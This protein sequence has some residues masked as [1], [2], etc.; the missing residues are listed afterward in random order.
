MKSRS[1]LI[2]VSFD[3]AHDAPGTVFLDNGQTLNVRRPNPGQKEMFNTA[4]KL[5]M[6]LILMCERKS[7][8]IFIWRETG[9]ERH[10]R[11]NHA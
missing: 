3:I 8:S 1:A 9:I 5:V 6:E 10:S 11:K 4:E 7:F 2:L